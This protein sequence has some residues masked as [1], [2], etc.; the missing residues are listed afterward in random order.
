MNCGLLNS[1]IFTLFFDFQSFDLGFWFNSVVVIKKKSKV[2]VILILLNLQLI[3]CIRVQKFYFVLMCFVCHR[4][5]IPSA[6][7]NALLH[8]LCVS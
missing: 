5:N 2:F 8:V 6:L 1:V 3:L 7:K 4:M